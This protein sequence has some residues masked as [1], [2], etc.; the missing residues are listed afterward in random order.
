M[1]LAC[2]DIREHQSC[3]LPLLIGADAG[4]VVVGIL[5][6]HAGFND[7]SGGE[8]QEAA[9]LRH[10]QDQKLHPLLAVQCIKA[11]AENIQHGQCQHKRRQVQRPFQ[12]Q[13][14]KCTQENHRKQ[15]NS[16]YEFH[17]DTAFL[18]SVYG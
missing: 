3:G 9:K 4:D 16:C 18:L 7:R 15:E 14:Q 13:Y 17:I 5:A 8:E 6:E 2:G 11:A 10:Q 1:H 12:H